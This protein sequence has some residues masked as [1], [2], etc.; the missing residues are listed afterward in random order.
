MLELRA[1][2]FER[3]G[4]VDGNAMIDYPIALNYVYIFAILVC[5]LSVLIFFEEAIKTKRIS[6]NPGATRAIFGKAILISA[7][8]TVMTAIY[9]SF[10][11]GR[12]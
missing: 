4:A 7:I 8:M 1:N 6:I 10:G 2:R 12:K 9:H 3:N 11:V 5:L